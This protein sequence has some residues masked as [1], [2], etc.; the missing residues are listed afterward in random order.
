M[1]SPAKINLGLRILGRRDDGYHDIETIFQ[2][3]S[4]TD[5]IEFRP[6]DDFRLTCT[7][8]TLD[9]GKGNLI[10]IAANK[11]AQATGHPLQGKVHLIKRIPMAAGLGGGSG[12]A[13]VA[14]HGLCRLWD[15]HPKPGLLEQLAGEIGADCSFFLKGGL[16]HATGRGEQLTWLD[17]AVSGT[18]LLIVPAFPV[19]TAWAYENVQILL[20]N[21]EKNSILKDC[22]NSSN[23]LR[24]LANRATNDLEPG[25]FR[26]FPELKSIKRELQSTKAEL[27]ALSGSGNALFGI[28]QDRSRAELAAQH[29]YGRYRTFICSP[30]ARQRPTAMQS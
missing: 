23:L 21:R 13:A 7:D 5:T 22:I 29:F 24:A 9:C 17:G 10:T 2:E 16:A 25:V 6:S 14:L 18:I 20:T 27:T 26:R 1:E 30:I 4:L 19:Q 11:L 15:I 3:I 28:Y 12:N 8:E